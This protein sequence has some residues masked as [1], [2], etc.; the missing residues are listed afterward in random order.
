MTRGLPATA[1]VNSRPLGSER[2]VR[3]LAADRILPAGWIGNDLV[4][5]S[6]CGNDSGP[7]PSP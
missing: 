2:H 1:E 4:G 6:S 3:K 5:F 7:C